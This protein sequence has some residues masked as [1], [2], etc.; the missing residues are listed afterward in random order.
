MRAVRPLVDK[1]AHPS[2]LDSHHVNDKKC[3][4]TYY[5]GKNGLPEIRSRPT[6][7]ELE[8]VSCGKTE[9]PV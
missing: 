6:G 5:L 2:V 4:F 8:F 1:V 3:V 9:D 7:R